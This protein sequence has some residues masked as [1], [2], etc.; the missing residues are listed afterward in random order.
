MGVIL[1][2][3][4]VFHL[5]LFGHSNVRSLTFI[6]Y[7]L[8]GGGGGSSF[9]YISIVYHYMQKGGRGSKYHVQ[10]CR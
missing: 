9:L 6:M 5:A 7:G 3:V 2:G 4:I 8:G 10:L 1:F